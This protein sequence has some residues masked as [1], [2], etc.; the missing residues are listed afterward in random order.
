L[1]MEAQKQRDEGT[2]QSSSSKTKPKRS[3]APGPIAVQPRT[4]PDEVRAREFLRQ[5]QQQKEAPFESREA[6]RERLMWENM[7]RNEEHIARMARQRQEG[8]RKEEQGHVEAWRAREREEAARILNQHNFSQC[9]TQEG[10]FTQN[11]QEDLGIDGSQGI[12]CSQASGEGLS[13]EPIQDHFQLP[14]GARDTNVLE[15]GDDSDL[16]EPVPLETNAQPTG[17]G[18]CQILYEEQENSKQLLL[19]MC[20]GLTSPTGR[21]LGDCDE[22]PYKSVKSV[23]SVHPSLA[24]LREEMIRRAADRG[25]GEL[26]KKT[27][28]KPACLSWLQQHPEENPLNRAWLMREEEQYYRSLTKGT[29]E[30]EE[31]D[32]SASSNW[33]SWEPFVRFYSIL[34]R[35]EIR[36]ALLSKDDTLPRQEMEARNHDD[37]PLDFYELI[38]KFYNDDSVVITTIILPDLWYTWAYSHDLYFHDM[39]GGEITAEDAK[40]RLSDC[41]A[42]LIYVSERV[43]AISVS[44]SQVLKLL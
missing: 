20:I 26:R 14:E 23:R 12:G 35:D 42:K 31:Q 22:E 39:P 13:Q 41:R 8:E 29:E 10:E 21:K 1:K 43:I 4:P 30:R 32:K 3:W 7:Q 36:T 18:S 11:E 33:N 9:S 2:R 38:A 15:T 5:Q 24:Q 44:W 34:C 6:A 25:M 37:R 19:A 27:A 17:K 28:P 40:K 16:E